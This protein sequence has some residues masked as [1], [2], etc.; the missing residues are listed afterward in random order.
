MQTEKY[1]NNR[2]APTTHRRRGNTDPASGRNPYVI[3]I[4]K[5]NSTISVRRDSGVRGG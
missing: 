1:P 2:A 3:A 5:P 4:A